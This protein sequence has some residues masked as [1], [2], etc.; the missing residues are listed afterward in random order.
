MVVDSEDSCS[1]LEAHQ[2]VLLPMLAAAMEV[3]KL[4]S[5]IPP[6]TPTTA[7]PED[8]GFF[9]STAPIT[10]S[11]PAARRSL[12]AKKGSI[13][14]I[15]SLSSESDTMAHSTSTVM[16]KLAGSPTS[17]SGAGK[18]S[19]TVMDS[20]KEKSDGRPLR[21]SKRV[22]ELFAAQPQ[23]SSSGGGQ[24]STRATRARKGG[25]N[26]RNSLS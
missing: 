26:S 16:P 21:R 1:V 7:K 11:L 19:P 23:S 3:D 8:T 12:H 13:S 15:S 5:S 24:P 20:S 6:T 9:G 22:A 18:R 14:S 17:T 10:A 4:P 25:S 2:Q